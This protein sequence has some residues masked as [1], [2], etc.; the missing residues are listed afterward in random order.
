MAALRAMLQLR[1]GSSSSSPLLSATSTSTTPLHTNT[2]VDPIAYHSSTH[3]P[4]VAPTTIHPSSG[5]LSGVSQGKQSAGTSTSKKSNLNLGLHSGAASGNLGLVKFALDNGQPIDSVVNGVLPIHAACC[6]KTNMAVVLFLIECGADVNARRQPLKYGSERVGAQAVGT[7]GSTPL[8][9]AAANGCLTIVEILLRHGA[10][11]DLADKYGTTPFT[12]ATARHHPEVASVLYLHACMQRGIQAITPD[13][14]LGD[15]RDHD[16]FTSPRNSVDLSRRVS[17]IMAPTRSSI[18][19]QNEITISPRSPPPSLIT[20]AV[21]TGPGNTSRNIVSQRRVS[22][23]CIIESPTSP[24]ASSASS[25]PR[26]SCDLGRA[27]L[28][29][30][31]LQNNRVGGLGPVDSVTV[32]TPA[33]SP[34]TQPQTSG[35]RRPSFGLGFKDKSQQQRQQQQQQQQQQPR[36]PRNEAPSIFMPSQVIPN[37]TRRRSMDISALGLVKSP[38]T[39]RTLHRRRSLDI[40]GAMWPG[41]SKNRRDSGT[42]TSETI[43]SDQSSCPTLVNSATTVVQTSPDNSKRHME[44][45]QVHKD[46]HDHKHAHDSGMTSLDS[47]TSNSLQEKQSTS[48]PRRSP[49]SDVIN[50]SCRAAS[51]SEPG[52]RQSFDLRWF[53]PSDQRQDLEDVQD[54]KSKYGRRH[55]IQEAFVWKDRNEK[56]SLTTA[57]STALFYNNNS[58]NAVNTLN[59]NNDKRNATRHRASFTGSTTISGRFSRFWSPSVGKESLAYNSFHTKNGSGDAMKEMNDDPTPWET[60]EY[61]A[62]ATTQDLITKDRTGDRKARPGMM[63][64]FTGMWS[65]R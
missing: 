43:V 63:N 16:P 30:E 41:E 53:A 15:S 34:T 17:A 45:S 60:S 61:T 2:N 26:H 24:T 50:T 56:T 57:V 40:L 3:L 36:S 10:I 5:T 46:E 33:T 28:S 54:S 4:D 38:E 42:S 32:T 52:V 25:A 14:D 27:P 12:V 29:T 7:I 9:F 13:L 11:A 47:D 35:Y 19:A 62:G 8:H 64:R 55:S 20:T 1:P 44:A 21:S 23:P 59:S 58:S 51:M 39:T 6:G 49:I 65:R 37:T 48:R 18:A 31:P 22:L